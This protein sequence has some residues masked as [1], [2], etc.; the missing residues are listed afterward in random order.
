MTVPLVV[1]LNHHA[2]VMFYSAMMEFQP[3]MM[4]KKRK[5]MIVGKGR[6]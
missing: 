5:Q 6:M 1:E 2:D 3:E 4:C